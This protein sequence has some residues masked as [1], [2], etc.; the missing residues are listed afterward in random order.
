LHHHGARRS[1]G[2]QRSR[3]AHPL[4]GGSPRDA[5]PAHARGRAHRAG[6]PGG[7]DADPR[8]RPRLALATRPP[9]AAPHPRFA[10]RG[11]RRRSP[12]KGARHRTSSPTG[13]AMT[14]APS[15]ETILVER[16]GRVLWITLN[17]PERKNPLGAQMVNEL[18]YAL[19]AAKDDDE[20][21][22]VVLTGAGNAFSAG[23]DLKQFGQDAGSKL[24]LKGDFPDLL[25]R[26]RELGKPVIARVPGIAMGG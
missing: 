25:L 17:K 7:L 4:G 22:A 1:H 20:V 18:L 12:P 2:A 26:F 23:A 6:D 24:P 10:H 3:R 14:E 8:R 21:R 11:G 15:Y 13:D 9:R 16:R 5:H 19:D